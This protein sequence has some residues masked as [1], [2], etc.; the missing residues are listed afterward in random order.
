MSFFRGIQQR[1]GWR[2]S[3]CSITYPNDRDRFKVCLAC[4]DECSYMSNAEVDEDW[5]DKVFDL[6]M[7]W[8]GGD[9]GTV[10]T[11]WAQ[12]TP[13]EGKSDSQEGS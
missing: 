1:G 3:L 2:C 8:E 4:R 6:V 11:E 7:R 12:E 10:P 9:H 5:L 13:P